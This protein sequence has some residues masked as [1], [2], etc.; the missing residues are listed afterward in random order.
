MSYTN[1]V[2]EAKKYVNTILI[3]LEDMYY[4]QYDHTLDV[5]ERATYLSEKEWLS[6]DDI[7]MMQLAALFHDTGFIIQYDHNEP[8]GAK[9]ASNFLKTFL[10]PG[11]KIK[12][13]E[14]IILATDP[15]YIEPKDI[16][17]EII[18]DAD[19]DNLWR[20]DF[21]EKWS[22]VKTEVEIL[23]NIKIKDPD[24]HHAM[25]DVLYKNKFYTKT[26]IDERQKKKDENI[27]LLQSK[28]E[29]DDL[30]S[31]KLEIRN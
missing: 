9:F 23:K 11:D 18:K 25:L 1:I 19:I 15:Q 10:Y 12:V 17:E 21:F 3:S 14:R 28:I 7:E 29:R 26:Q 24:W 4:H 6:K 2:I 22:K 16:Y 13:I 31:E 20:E 27:A 5:L 8:I 30:K